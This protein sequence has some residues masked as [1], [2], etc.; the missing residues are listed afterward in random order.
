MRPVVSPHVDY[1]RVADAY[2]R[3]RTPSGTSL[4]IWG[5]EIGPHLEGSDVVV[6]LAAGTGAFSGAL[7]TWGAR[8]VVAVEPSTAM[9]A[10]ATPERG[11]HQVNGRA[12]AIPLRSGTADAIWIS[13]AFNHFEEPGVAVGECRRVLGDH[14]KVLIR[15]FVPGHTELPWLSLFPGFE[16]AIARFPSLVTLVELFGDA[17]FRLVADRRVEEWTQTY[18]D[19]ADFSESMR[20]ADSI[21]TALSDDEVDAGLAALRARPTE[22]DRFALSFLVWA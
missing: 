5:D 20:Y 3:R 2:V 10:K 12:E 22:I 13:T 16:K 17:G 15:G 1:E 18:A 9:Q 4:S 19:R 7:R 6:D 14:G 11:V 8:R 21:L